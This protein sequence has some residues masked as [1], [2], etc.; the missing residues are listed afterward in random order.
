M[1]QGDREGD[2]AAENPG[3]AGRHDHPADFDGMEIDRDVGRRRAGDPGGD[4]RQDEQGADCYQ[5]RADGVF[6]MG[7]PG[8][9]LQ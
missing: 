4:I 9:R 2:D 1:M 8:Q 5:H 7:A 3:L 6:E